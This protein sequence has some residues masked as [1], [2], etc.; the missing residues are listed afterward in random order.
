MLVT[1]GTMCKEHNVAK[2]LR[3][4]SS[5]GHH[6]RGEL[7]KAGRKGGGRKPCQK[8]Q[9]NTANVYGTA[10]ENWQLKKNCY[11]RVCPEGHFHQIHKAAS[12]N[13]NLVK[14]LRNIKSNEMLGSLF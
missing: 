1:H 9:R 3:A 14:F 8:C 5:W 12:R 4:G 13:P 10:Y 2:L 6:L 7:N 11:F